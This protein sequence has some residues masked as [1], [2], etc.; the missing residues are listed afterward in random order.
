[1]TKEGY[2]T[3]LVR[4]KDYETI[5]SIAKKKNQSIVKTVSEILKEF[6]ERHQNA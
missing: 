4:I 2:H 3:I 1:L 5:S 6:V